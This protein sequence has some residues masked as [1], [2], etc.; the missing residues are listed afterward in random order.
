[1]LSAPLISVCI[2]SYNAEQFI[3]NTLQSVIDQTFTDFEVVIVDDASTDRTVAILQEFSDSRI[4]LNRNDLNLGMGNNWN[5][6]VSCARGKYVKLLCGDDLLDPQCLERQAS[7]LES[8]LNS[9]AVLAVCGSRVINSQGKI[10]LRRTLPFRSG[11]VAG[12]KMIR[13]SVRWG[14]NLIGEPMVGLY[15]RDVLDKGIRYSPSNPFLIDLAF[16][17]DLLR[18][19]NAFVDKNPLA[20]FRV[21]GRAVSAQ[22]GSRQAQAFRDFAGNLHSERAY[23]VSRCDVL[24]GSLLSFAWCI[25]RNLFL[26]FKC[27]RCEGGRTF[28]KTSKRNREFCSDS[29]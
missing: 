11:L 22:I 21:S 6:V 19:G 2:P 25:S 7:T 14:T 16:W 26:K 27:G 12:E 20:S 13:T 4:R 10:V 17:A 3:A 5:K 23:A 28:D 18:H 24:L 8:A 15:R 9:R 29:I 1:M